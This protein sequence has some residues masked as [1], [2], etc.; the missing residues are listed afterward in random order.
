MLC[1]VK[2]MTKESE[3]IQRVLEVK[4]EFWDEIYPRFFPVR[5]KQ[6]VYTNSGFGIEEMFVEKNQLVKDF[7]F[8]NDHDAVMADDGLEWYLENDN[9]VPTYGVADNLDQV[10]ETF[11]LDTIPEKVALFGTDIHKADQP[12]HG[13]WRWHKW[14][15][16]IGENE[17]TTEY[18]Y[19]EPD[20]ESVVCFHIYRVN[21]DE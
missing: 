8:L 18:L 21:S 6:G 15:T 20:V 3:N 2:F 1:D 17:P 13:G 19:D 16:Y 14:G 9:I 10:I 4:P 11:K 5:L 7:F 12:K